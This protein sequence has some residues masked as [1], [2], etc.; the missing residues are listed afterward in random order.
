MKKVLLFFFT[1]CTVQIVIGQTPGNVSAGLRLW[2]KADA[3]VT[4]SA[5]VSSWTDHAGIS[6]ATAA[7]GGGTNPALITNAMNFNPGIRF[8]TGASNY[9]KTAVNPASTTMTLIGVY[10]TSQSAGSSQFYASPAIIGG[11]TNSFQNDYALGF[12]NGNL[13]IKATSGDNFNI[14]SAS[15][16]NNGIPH[17]A[18][19]TR[20]NTI[21]AGSINLYTNGTNVGGASS[22]V[23]VLSDPG[24]VGIGNH[25]DAILQAQFD[26]DIAEVIIYNSVLSGAERKRVEGYLA[27]KY[28]ITLGDNYLASDGLT[29]VYD[30]TGYSNNIAGIGRD[31]NTGLYQKQ[32]K[33]SNSPAEVLMS[34]D[35]AA[36]DNATNNG[37]LVNNQFLVWGDDGASG[38]SVVTDIPGIDKRFLKWW[39]VSNTNSISQAIAV[40]YPVNG[41]VLYSSPHLI[42]NVSAN[43]LGAVTTPLSNTIVVVDGMSYYS[44][45]YTFAPGD[46]Y[47][48]F[49]SPVQYYPKTTAINLA[50]PADWTADITGTGGASPFNFSTEGDVFEVNNNMLNASFSGAWAIDGGANV[51]ITNSGGLTATGTG[52]L[53][54]GAMSTFDCNSLP[55]VLQSTAN[56]TAAI[57]PV[58][59]TLSNANN[60]TVERYITDTYTRRW[61]LLS[62]PVTGQA[63]YNG[64]QE[65]GN[66]NSSYG[67]F[68]T[69]PAIYNNSLSNDAISGFDRVSTN[70]TGGATTS[71]RGITAD[72]TL[73]TLSNT[74]AVLINANPAWFLFVRSARPAGSYDNS[75]TAATTL[76]TTGLLNQG[77]YNTTIAAGA[78]VVTLPNPYASPLDI[79]G[80][81]LPSTNGTD[82]SFYA[83][84]PAYGG[85]LG[86]YKLYT[87]NNTLATGGA[88][89]SVMNELQSNQAIFM[90]K[91]SA[92]VTATFT[93]GNKVQSVYG[94]VLRTTNASLSKSIVIKLQSADTA[95]AL[96]ERDLTYAQFS[97]ANSN[98]VIPGEDVEKLGNFNENLSLYRNGSYLY[99]E[100]M[101]QPALDDSLYVQLWKTTAQPY[102]LQIESNGLTNNVLPY[103][104]DNKTNTETPLSVG[105]T[106]LYNFTS[107]GGNSDLGR[108]TIVFRPATALPVSIISIN[109]YK[110]NTGSNVDWKVAQE[111]GVVN[112]DVEK[113]TDGVAFT[114]FATVS[115]TNTATAHTYSS[116]DA[117]PV[118]G[119]NYY[120]VRTNGVNGQSTLTAI[121]KLVFGKAVKPGISIY[122]NP[123]KGSV[124]TVNM[125][126]LAKGVYSLSI[127]SNDGKQVA[128]KNIT[129]SNSGAV[130]EQINLPAGTAKGIYQLKLTGTNNFTQQLIVE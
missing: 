110:Q 21:A 3:G 88:F 48:T 1:I 62:P 31:D 119:T 98:A 112:Y 39:K 75:V 77:T 46:T 50:E 60:V 40:L 93:E 103:L 122:P 109:A 54:I 120:R 13:A 8:Y 114:K 121:V 9:L 57:G 87:D 19:G 105:G 69:N 99:K 107:D 84:D 24:G 17:I 18:I 25:Y 94:N 14:T 108:F 86:G 28:G 20:V 36:A 85:S 130:N 91:G 11:E 51:M 111:S 35:N 76:R 52:Y 55:F 74:N 118:N 68:I 32:S 38:A 129:I 44:V 96:T 89:P 29:T 30:T 82:R 4:G 7:G 115:A 26:G 78:G 72:G 22:D 117:A 59:G 63:I 27:L 42:S 97:P 106:D 95:G 70:L 16:T 10:K 2:L 43:T 104:I 61:H 56:N 79:S 15:P 41:F 33:S 37:V 73:T 90:V 5:T 80:S 23:N 64:W 127:Y 100:V 113:S 101:K 47:F 6:N 71:I 34:L 12:N 67:T 128:T 126:G 49:G 66:N 58:F 45:Q 125:E 124:V 81:I 53:T 65:S 116:Y 83:W 102:T 92:G 123:V